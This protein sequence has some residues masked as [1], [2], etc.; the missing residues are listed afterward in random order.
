MAELTGQGHHAVTNKDRDLARVFQQDLAERLVD[1]GGDL[2]IGAQE[3]L[4]QVVAADDADKVARGI[5]HRQPPDMMRI[6][7]PGGSAERRVRVNRDHRGRHQLPSVFTRPD[8]QLRDDVVERVIAGRFAF[9][10]DAFDVS[11]TSGIVTITGQVERGALASQLVDAVRHL[12][13]VVD[14]RDRVS[15]PAQALPQGT[16]GGTQ[17]DHRM[18]GTIP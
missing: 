9:N 8:G 13:G 12:E 4:H 17:N 2:L 6:H 15:Y 3:D 18:R 10:P 11:V 5:D 16:S 14:V 1:L 7:Q